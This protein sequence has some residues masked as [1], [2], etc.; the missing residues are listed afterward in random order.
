MYNTLDEY[1]SYN[2]D[3]YIKL[4]LGCGSKY[5]KGWCNIDG[6]QKSASDTHRGD[7]KDEPDLWLDIRELEADNNSIDVICSQHVMEHFYR[8][9]VIKIFRNFYKK[10]KP[11]GIVI[12]EM[13]DLNKIINLIFWLPL[14]PKYGLDNLR[15]RDMITSQLY[16]AAWEE[17]EIGYPYHKYIWEKKE[18]INTLKEIGFIITLATGATKSHVPFRDMA[19]I[20]QKPVSEGD[21]SLSFLSRDFKKSY[22]SIY[23]RVFIQVKTILRLLKIAFLQ[24]LKVDIKT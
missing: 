7:M 23:Y 2:S 15:N 17:N 24:L 3:K 10:L 16:G 1:I 9:E 22:G 21:S 5:W 6:Y 13:P 19:V 14:R 4:H 18:F 12:T 11:G 20:C 8:Y